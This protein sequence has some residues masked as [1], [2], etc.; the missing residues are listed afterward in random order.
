MDQKNKLFVGNLSYDFNEQTLRAAL[1]TLFSQVGQVVEVSVPIFRDTGKIKGIAFVTM[2]SEEEATAALDKLEGYEFGAEGYN[3]RPLHLD[4]AKP[5][6]P[7]SNNFSS[8]AG[9][10][11]NKGGNGGYNKGGSSSYSNGGRSNRSNNNW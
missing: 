10:Y 3:T 7:R 2:G 9:S 1:E 4:L 5:M 8:G 6:E 11:S